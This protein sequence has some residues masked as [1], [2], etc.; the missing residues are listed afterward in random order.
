M[1]GWERR[2]REDRDLS[3][4]EEER[5]GCY[6]YVFREM[7]RRADRKASS[8]SSCTLLQPVKVQTC[9]NFRRLSRS[10]ELARTVFYKAVAFFA[11]SIVYI[12]TLMV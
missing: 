4:G 8:S 9:R 11:L 5:V 1:C 7:S 12:A 2:K 3:D 10:M 6:G